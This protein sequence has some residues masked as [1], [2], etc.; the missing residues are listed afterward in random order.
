MVIDLLRQRFMCFIHN[1][2]N[3]GGLFLCEYFRKLLHNKSN[4]NGLCKFGAFYAKFFA[5]SWSVLV[6]LISLSLIVWFADYLTFIPWNLIVVF[7][8]IHA[9]YI[10]IRMM[11][12]SPDRY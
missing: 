1:S 6:A 9:V 4:K 8:I 10:I 2:L 11:L 12:T 7:I 5:D 3:A